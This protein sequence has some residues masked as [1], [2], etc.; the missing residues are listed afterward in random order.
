MAGLKAM[1]AKRAERKKFIEAGNAVEDFREERVVKP[2]PTERS[3][4]TDVDKDDE[5]FI[6]IPDIHSYQRDKKAFDLMME[7]LPYLADKYNVTKF[8]Q[9]GD[10]LE[11]GAASTHPTTSVYER[12]PDYLDEIEWVMNDFW[13]PAMKACP[14]ANFYALMGNH[15]HRWDKKIAKQLMSKN[16]VTQDEAQQMYE[17][18]MPTDLYESIGVHVTPYGNEAVGE[19]ILELIPNKLLAV[20]GWSFAKHSSATHLNQLQGA[21]SLLYGHT[22]RAQSHVV[23]NPVTRKRVEAWSFGALAKC[24]MKWHG[25]NPTEHVLGFG[26]VNVYGEHFNIQPI[27]IHMNADDSRTLILPDGKVLKSK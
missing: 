13:Q 10:A 2:L 4:N 24:E 23:R 7:S 12:T 20:H 27:A 3:I 5:C 18:K 22:H 8:V 1:L 11:V 9:L 26:I 6:I 17:D 14:D 19:G 25:G 16:L 15:E 21:Y